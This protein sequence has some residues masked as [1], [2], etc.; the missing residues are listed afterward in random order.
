MNQ[1][2]LPLSPPSFIET[3]F[4]ILF[5]CLVLNSPYINKTDISTV[6]TVLERNLNGPRGSTMHSTRDFVIRVNNNRISLSFAPPWAGQHHAQNPPKLLGIGFHFNCSIEGVTS[7][8]FRIGIAQMKSQ[9][10]YFLNASCV[11]IRIPFQKHDSHII[12][13]MSVKNWNFHLTLL[14]LCLVLPGCHWLLLRLAWNNRKLSTQALLLNGASR[15]AGAL[16]TFN[17]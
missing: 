16:L 13:K 7:S 3:I 17:W 9:S 6:E 1:S 11:G 10:L 12:Y 8:C 5:E 2:I 14:P 15:L 4:P